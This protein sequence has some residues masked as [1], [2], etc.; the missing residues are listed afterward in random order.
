M[1][2]KD[3]Y[4]LSIIFCFL[5][6]SAWTQPAELTGIQLVGLQNFVKLVFEFDKQAPE[7]KV[8]IRNETDI[9]VMAVTLQGGAFDQIAET[10]V[11]RPVQHIQI[12]PPDLVSGKQ[13]E[14]LVYLEE[15]VDFKHK[16]NDKSIEVSLSWIQRTADR[17]PNKL[18]KINY[19][20]QEK[21]S[22]SAN[23][24]FENNLED[25]SVFLTIDKKQIIGVFHNAEA[26]EGALKAPVS[27]L[28]SDFVSNTGVSSIG[29]PYLKL[30]FH[31]HQE[32]LMDM[33]KEPQKVFIDI[34][35]VDNQD[36]T[37]EETIMPLG[38]PAERESPEDYSYPQPSEKGGSAKWVY[39]GIGAVVL[40]GGGAGAYYWYMNQDDPLPPDP[41]IPSPDESL[42][43][44]LEPPCQ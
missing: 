10:D 35:G 40:I 13:M 7:Y 2:K 23:F 32:L 41:T 24:D 31:S 26:D 8:S 5:I 39:M 21:N 1:N 44:C 17:E 15:K 19:T 3:S 6:S 36:L 12:F 33:A 38:R 11:T 18:K 34:Y 42:F 43:P 4:I 25:Q 29:K 16:I 27:N 9:T 14:V 20:S 28:I 37:A 22:L 30:I